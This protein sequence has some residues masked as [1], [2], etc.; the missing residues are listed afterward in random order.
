MAVTNFYVDP[1]SGANTNGGSSFGSAKAS[2]T[3]GST[4]GTSTVDLSGDTPD[5]SGVSVG[6]S[7]RLSAETVG[8]GTGGSDIFEITAVD[9]GADTVTVTP[10]PGTN[11]G[12]TWAIGGSFATLQKAADVAINGDGEIRCCKT[13]TESVATQIDFDQNSGSNAT[14]IRVRSYNSAGSAP[15]DGYTLQATASIT[16]IIAIGTVSDLQFIGLYL[17]GNSNA[18]YCLNDPITASLD[19][20]WLRCK[21]YNATSHGFYF[22]MNDDAAQIRECEAYSNGGSGFSYATVANRGDAQF[23]GCISHDNTSHGFQFAAAKCGFV[24]CEAY[25]NGGDGFNID[26]RGGE[27]PVINCT[28]YDNGGDGFSIDRVSGLTCVNNTAVG[29]T[30][31]GFAIAGVSEDAEATFG[32]NHTDANGTAWDTTAP[33]DN[34]QTGDPQFFDAST[35]D[36]R[37]TNTSPLIGNGM[38][39]IDIGARRAIYGGARVIHA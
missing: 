15:E 7:I 30:A 3:S 36:F 10:T 39:G 5:L 2:G 1:S 35:G 38:M 28:S 17:D 19:L 18:T 14:P 33:G 23:F 12:Q 37:P 20:S 13:A 26:G 21:F 9:D 8:R 22:D 11:S 6:D 25:G 24:L 16:A 31:Y 4:N 34:N 32:Y 27:T 29:N